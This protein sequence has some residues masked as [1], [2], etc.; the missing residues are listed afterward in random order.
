MEW[1][2]ST[3]SSRSYHQDLSS[4]QSIPSTQSQLLIHAPKENYRL[5]FNA[6]VPNTT[7]NDEAIIQV[8]TLGLNPIDWKGPA[9][10]FG[11]PSFPCVLGREFVGVVVKPPKKASRIKL[12]DVVLAISTDYRD[13]RKAAFQQFAVAQDSN[14]CR[15]PIS[16]PRNIAASAGVAF[17]TATILLGVC[18][19][20]KLPY[21]FNLL[22]EVRAQ[23]RDS[24]PEDIREE[25][26]TAITSEECLKPGEWLAVWGAGSTVGFVTLQLAKLA[27]VRVIAVA[28]AVKRGGLLVDAGVDILVHREHTDEAKAI[29]QSVTRRQLRFGIDTVGKESAEILQET[30]NPGLQQRAHLIGLTG[31]P[32]ETPQRIVQHKVPI[33]LFHEK[34]AIGEKIMICMEKLLRDGKLILPEVETYSHTGLEAINDAL[35]KLSSGKMKGQRMVVN[36]F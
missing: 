1:T 15:L 3:D 36:M 12:G 4:C 16:C 24:L 35:G 11:L 20:L 28:D 21:D 9:F 27:G 17:V 7:R 26:H 13:Y 31:L 18:L 8:Q 34:P 10:N 19:G 29:I 22:E 14:L 25:C 32:R 33:K 2:D 5:V 30:L 6:S 23:P